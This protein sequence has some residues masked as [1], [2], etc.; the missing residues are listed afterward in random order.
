MST[1]KEQAVKVL[2]QQCRKWHGDEVNKPTIIDAFEKLFRTGD[3]MFLDQIP[4]E[5]KAEFLNKE[6]QYFIPGRIVI[7]DSVTNPS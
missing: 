1:N 5:V 6:V 4:E 7:Q 2:D 3:T